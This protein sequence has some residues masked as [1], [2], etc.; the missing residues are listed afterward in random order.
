MKIINAV[1]SKQ[2]GGLEQASLDYANA[3]RTAGHDITMLL[4]SR[5][6]FVADAK[7]T[8]SAI[9]Q[10]DN[11]YGHMD[12]PAIWR[13]RRWLKREQPDVV[14]AHGNRAVSLLR[15]AARGVVPVIA[16][17]HTTSVKRSLNADAAIMVNEELKQSLLALGHE[18]PDSVYVLPNM[19]TITTQQRQL[20]YSNAPQSVPIIGVL[21]RFSPEKG[22]DILLEAAAKL[23]HQGVDFRIR[24][25]GD[26]PLK[27]EVVAAIAEY[28]IEKYVELCGWISDREAFYQ[29]LDIYCLPSRAETFG[30]VVLE[31]M[32]RKIPVVAT[33]CVGV[34]QLV[35]NREVALLIPPEDADA[36]AN[37]LQ[38]ML[39]DWDL[40]KKYA[41][42]GFELVTEKYD[43]QIVAG[44]LQ[45]IITQVVGNYA[46]H[47]KQG[48]DA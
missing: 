23:V 28:K 20:R 39:E 3:L 13:L 22:L 48:A 4:S 34:R 2:N 31:A 32:Q 37:G 9:Y 27:D 11:R 14:L 7:G 36:L 12:K 21:A 24:I 17:N 15:K 41:Q 30:I 42:A 10:I 5:C 47:Q 18:N 8:N 16:V 43:I 29:S 33:R 44:Q 1:L 19:V 40:A 45:K 6:P 46:Q 35:E 25:G 38:Q 26:G